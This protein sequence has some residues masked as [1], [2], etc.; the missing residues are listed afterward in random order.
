[1]VLFG[2]PLERA[3]YT[4][5]YRKILAAAGED[6]AL[7][8]PPVHDPQAEFERY[9]A[10]RTLYFPQDRG[11]ANAEGNDLIARGL[12]DFLQSRKLLP[13]RSPTGM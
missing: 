12:A 9:T 8:K 5:S 10:T 2:Y 6:E 1:M 11:H 3:G 4:A 7:G 13:G